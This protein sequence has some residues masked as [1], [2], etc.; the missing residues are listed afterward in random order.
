MLSLLLKLC[1]L[2]ILLLE[3]G[4]KANES[5][6]KAIRTWPVP[7]SIHDV[8][9]FHGLV[10]F[11]GRFIH[12]FSTIMAPMTEVI[13]GTSFVWTPKAQFAFEEIK[14][15]LTQAPVCP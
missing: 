15:R 7:R 9:A 12:G 3:M 10:S 14:T 6:V 13:K 2:V 1:F 11:Y 4:I 5:K 8:R